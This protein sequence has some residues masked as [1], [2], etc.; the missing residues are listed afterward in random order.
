[1][2]STAN[3]VANYVFRMNSLFDP[4]LLV[5]DINHI[6]DQLATIYQRYT[7]IGSKLTATF[8]PIPA[9]INGAGTTQLNGPV[10]CAVWEILLHKHNYVVYNN[11]D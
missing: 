4:D 6:T 10:L 5:L 11:G 7:V 2:T 1:M 9:A 3:A 8:T